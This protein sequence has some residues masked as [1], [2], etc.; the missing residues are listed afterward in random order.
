MK[1]RC[2]EKLNMKLRTHL[3]SMSLFCRSSSNSLKSA[4]FLTGSLFF[5]S[6]PRLFHA[7]TH[8]VMELIRKHESV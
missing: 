7:L 5:K 6:H 4:T 8:F 2:G 1:G 3:T